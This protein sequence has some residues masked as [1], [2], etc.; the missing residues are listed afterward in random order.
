MIGNSTDYAIAEGER[1]E[2]V[3][4]LARKSGSSVLAEDL[5]HDAIIKLMDFVR[6]EKVQHPRALLFK[7]AVN[8]LI[9]HQR[10]EKRIIAGL[11]IQIIIKILHLFLMI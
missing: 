10:R 5:A 4:F 6:R 7:I 9:N 8:L 2:L 1:R 3:I 11:Y